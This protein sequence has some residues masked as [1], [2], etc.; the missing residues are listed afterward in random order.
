MY[1]TINGT[2]K[3]WKKAESLYDITALSEVF[4]TQGYK[5]NY[6]EIIFGNGT[7]GRNLSTGDIV[8][9]FYRDTVG[10]GGNNINGFDF[11]NSIDGYGNITV[12]TEISSYGGSER[13]SNENIKFKAPRHFTTQERGVIAD[14]Y[15]NLVLINFPE[16]EAVNSYG[17]EKV[18]KFGK[19]IIVLKPYDSTTVSETLSGRIKT[20]LEEK[21]L[22]DEVIIENLEFFYIEITSDVKYNKDD[23]IL[24]EAG[25]KTIITQN[26]VDL[27][28]TRFNKFN[29]NVYSSQIAA[30]IDNSD[31]SIISNSTF[32]R[33]GHRLTP[34]V[35]VNTS[36]IFDFE[37]KLDLHTPSQNAGH[38]ST[39]SSSTFTYTKDDVDYDSCIEDDGNGVLK[40]YTT[41]NTGT[42]VALDTIGSVDYETGKIVFNLAI[43]GYIGYI[44]LFASIKSRDLEVTKNKFII[45]DSS[46]FNI[47]MVETNA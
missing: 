38:D 12:I 5:D 37:N 8:E 20:F 1:V 19:Q 34:V 47:T 15:T 30:I 33:L 45:I 2:R 13:E 29:Q 7:T 9:I 41:D 39:I 25:L 32:L 11:S 26:L 14:D 43:K 16:I 22:A 46:D 17:G 27:N 44:S 42:S 36:Y 18:N 10:S 21:S 40:V 31:D 3:K 6:Y 24:N 28:T 23:T 4:F 35:N